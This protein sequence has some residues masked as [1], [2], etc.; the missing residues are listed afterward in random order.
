MHAWLSYHMIRILPRYSMNWKVWTLYRLHSRSPLRTSIFFSDMGLSIVLSL[1]RKKEKKEGGATP[2]FTERFMDGSL[3]FQGTWPQI[4]GCT[5]RQRSDQQP[6]KSQEAR[7]RHSRQGNL[8]QRHHQHHW[9]QR[10]LP[11][12]QPERGIQY[13]AHQRW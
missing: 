9:Y 3:A 6:Y 8:R 1:H 2:N 12:G 4:D 11:Q 5:C 10:F 7:S 13:K